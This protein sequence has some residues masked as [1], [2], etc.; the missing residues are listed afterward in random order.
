MDDLGDSVR[1]TRLRQC[2]RVTWLPHQK[3]SPRYETGRLNIGTLR[4][5]DN[6]DVEIDYLICDIQTCVGL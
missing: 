1:G 6:E 3:T 5:S 4:Y 2:P